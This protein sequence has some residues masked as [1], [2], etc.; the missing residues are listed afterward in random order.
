MT[1]N[2][3]EEDTVTDNN[4]KLSAAEAVFGIMGYLTSQPR[5]F[6]FS[7]NHCATH[8]AEIAGAFCEA[9][10][11]ASPR[12]DFGQHLKPI[13][14]LQ[15]TNLCR[16]NGTLLDQVRELKEAYLEVVPLLRTFA[17]RHRITIANLQKSCRLA[18][19]V[20]V[21]SDLVATD[22]ELVKAQDG[23]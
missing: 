4:D 7:E 13:E 9:N 12:S 2:T 3:N 11:L 8:G 1:R 10:G 19:A 21:L 18:Q 22:A 16:D 15:L 20:T 6:V 5:A 17:F 14:N 23:S